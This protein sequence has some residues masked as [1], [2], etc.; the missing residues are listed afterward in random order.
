MSFSHRCK[1]GRKTIDR[2]CTW[3]S[4]HHWCEACE[5]YY[6]VPH[7]AGCHSRGNQSH[8]IRG[9][10]CRYCEVYRTDGAEAA[11]AIVERWEER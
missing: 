4:D 7:D 9:C 1:P 6:G 10:A 3:H 2:K 11:R 8:S 5:G